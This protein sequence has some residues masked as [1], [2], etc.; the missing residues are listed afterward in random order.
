MRALVLVAVAGCAA[1]ARV[2]PGAFVVVSHAT[3]FHAAA[4]DDGIRFRAQ[5]GPPPT[6]AAE[7]AAGGVVLRVRAASAGWVEVTNPAEAKGHCGRALDEIEPFE[8]HFF[9]P[10]AALVPVVAR[11]YRAAYPDGTSIELRP[12]LPLGPP[13]AAGRF[14]ALRPEAR[15]E[16]ALP[17]DA[18]AR[19]YAGPAPAFAPA[20]PVP[21]D[22]P[23]LIGGARLTVGPHAVVPRAAM[24]VR[25]TPRGAG[26][27]VELADDCSKMT[28]LAAP[29]DVGMYG[30][31]AEGGAPGYAIG[32][33]VTDHDTR[34]LYPGTALFWA[35][36]TPAGQA[37]AERHYDL[38]HRHPTRPELACIVHDLGEP[39]DLL[40]PNEDH[41]AT[42][43]ELT[44]CFRYAES[45]Y[46]WEK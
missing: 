23:V 13:D 22:A 11:P 46:R 10:A 14:P 2:A 40:G 4:A 5:S 32:G 18:V 29:A 20:A 25:A 6:D 9:V 36:G 1:P 17:T 26:T 16:L 27:L 44:L 34:Y 37:R 42:P 3:T 28:A 12:G 24:A 45:N 7:D 31:G 21:D 41:E 33:G 15:L 39:R 38:W 19:G 35:D 43:T 8:L 30:M